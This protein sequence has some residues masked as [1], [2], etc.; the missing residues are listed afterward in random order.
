[1]GCVISSYTPITP[2]GRILTRYAMIDNNDKIGFWREVAK[3]VQAHNALTIKKKEYPCRFIMQLSHSGRQQDL[4]G[5][6]NQ[7]RTPGSSTN[8]KDFFHGI[9]CHAM[10]KAEIRK[11]VK[12]FGEAARRAQRAGLDGV[13]LHGA[14]GYLITQFLSS[15]INDRKDE[16][17]G[18]VENRARFVLEIVDSIKDKTEGEF[19]LQ[20]KINAADYNDWLYPWQK[21]GNELEDTIRICKLLEDAGVHAFHISSGSTFPHPRNP[22]GD[23][24]TN[25]LLRWYDG[26]ISQGVRAGFNYKIFGNRVT[27]WLFQKLWRWRRGTVIEG[28]NSEL[29][30][31]I[32]KQ[33]D[34]PVIVTG[35]FQH[36][37]KIASGLR[38][39]LYD[40]VSIGRP[41]I[42]NRDLP[43]ILFHQNGPEEG[44]ECTYC[45]RCLVN[46]LENPLGCYEIARYEGDSLEKKWSNL[47]KSVNSVFEP[48]TFP[49]GKD[50][51]MPDETGP[52][53]D[54]D[55]GSDDDEHE[56][57]GEGQA[58]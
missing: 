42:A 1:V 34:L 21:R 12:Q 2:E 17:G 47:V 45:N 6:E 22:P 19:H 25:E 41:L 38:G 8:K 28:I 35:G 49:S 9:L 15:A 56:D 39:E 48:P 10:D 3:R 11:T 37:D 4:S 32:K 20:M 18:S 53:D 40:G 51:L 29:A 46:D 13:E 55:E 5:F 52:S 50:D 16:Y 54:D 7:Y 30:G 44:K 43:E 58:S 23:L 33:T 36:A 14:N 31:E 26:M 24:P 27:A 57:D